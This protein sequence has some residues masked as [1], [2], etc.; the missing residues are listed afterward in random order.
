MYLHTVSNCISLITGEISPKDYQ[1]YYNIWQGSAP[2]Q[3]NTTM[4]ISGDYL[5]IIMLLDYFIVIFTE[6]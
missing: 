3:Y 5:I 2:Q 6:S 1:W 4:D